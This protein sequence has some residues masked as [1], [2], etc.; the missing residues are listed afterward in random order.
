LLLRKSFTTI[1]TRNLSLYFSTSEWR[2]SIF[3]SIMKILFS[4]FLFAA[5]V[6]R[7]SLPCMDPRVFLRVL[8]RILLFD[9]WVAFLWCSFNH[10][11]FIFKSLVRCIHLLGFLYTFYMLYK[12]PFQ[13][14]YVLKLPV[15]AF[16]L[17][18]LYDRYGC[19]FVSYYHLDV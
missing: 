12:K 1:K 15:P 14:I 10:L 4:H 3:K 16:L 7:V 17:A 6:V 11:S 13:H 19:L 2:N 9:N 18:K 5:L 8:Y